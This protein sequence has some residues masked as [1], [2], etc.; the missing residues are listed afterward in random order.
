MLEDLSMSFTVLKH[1]RTLKCRAGLLLAC[2]LLLSS[3][4]ACAVKSF[5]SGNAVGDIVV[6][7]KPPALGRGR[8]I[9]LHDE[10]D[11]NG[12]PYK[13]LRVMVQGGV[14]DAEIYDG[15]VW[16]IWVSTPGLLTADQVSVGSSAYAV[17]AKNKTAYPVIGSGGEIVLVAKDPC[18]LSFIT[19]VDASTESA[20][21]TRSSI[22]T[23]MKSGHVQKILVV[24]CSYPHK[25]GDQKGGN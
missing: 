17:L 24:G 23:E 7:R 18:G 15:M 9:Y 8:L 12:D 3:Q 21:M 2:G 22:A 13:L 19:D 4:T 6:G 16:R 1:L 10:Q 11:E 14:V 20:Q 5:I 25:D